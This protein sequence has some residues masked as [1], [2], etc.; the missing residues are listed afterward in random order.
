[1]TSVFNESVADARSIPQNE[2]LFKNYIMSA[3]H[4]EELLENQDE[5]KQGVLKELL[6]Y[7]EEEKLSGFS[8]A[9]QNLIKKAYKRIKL[10]ERDSKIGSLTSDQLCSESVFS[11]LTS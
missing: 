3:I 5:A 4:E 8:I 11:Q 7:W 2:V 9:D 10:V 6:E 1:M